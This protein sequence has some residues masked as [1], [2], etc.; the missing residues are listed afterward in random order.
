VERPQ[1]DYFTVYDARVSYYYTQTNDEF[2]VYI[3]NTTIHILNIS[4]SGRSIFHPSQWPACNDK[5][6]SWNNILVLH[7][8]VI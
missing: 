3:D 7:V 6:L 5:M 1:Y 8:N 4:K 2:S